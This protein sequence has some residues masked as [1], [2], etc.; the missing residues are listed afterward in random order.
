M[1]EEP[2]SAERARAPALSPTSPDVIAS[3]ADAGVQPWSTSRRMAESA[4][5]ALSS[6]NR[7]PLSVRR[8]ATTPYR[9]SQ[10]R[11]EATG[12]PVRAEACLM[13]NMV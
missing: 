5:I 9:R 1:A 12:T 3:A 7:Y 4:A 13:V 11:N 10:A 6:Y 8:G 2:P